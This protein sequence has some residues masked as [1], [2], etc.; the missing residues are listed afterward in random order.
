MNTSWSSEKWSGVKLMV[1]RP[2]YFHYSQVHSES[3][4]YYQLHFHLWVK[5]GLLKKLF[6]LDW[7]MREK[8]PLKKQLHKNVTWTFNEHDF[9]T[10]RHE[11]TLDGLT[12]SQN[13]SLN[14]ACISLITCGYLLKYNFYTMLPKV[15]KGNRVGMITCMCSLGIW[16]ITHLKR[17]QRKREFECCILGYAIN[18]LLSDLDVKSLIND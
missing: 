1:N 3:E 12:C 2:L 11:I 7:T 18:L 8:I 13:Q 10:S 4:W 16:R 9:L 5:K 17:R 15:K 14:Q 6:V